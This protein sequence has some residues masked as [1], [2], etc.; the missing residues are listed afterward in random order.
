M[1]TI[2]SSGTRRA[3]LATTIF[4]ALAS[5][6]S[7]SAAGTDT[8]SVSVYVKFADLDISTSAGAAKLYARIHAAAAGACSYYWFKS[9]AVEA[10]CILD[11]TANAVAD[12]N[13]PALV[14]VYNAKNKVP[15][16]TSRFSSTH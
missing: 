15:L 6:L 11:A 16:R 3:L 1:N 10:R 5:S 13:A 9:D 7:V 8:N 14:A 4:V 12:V 2:N